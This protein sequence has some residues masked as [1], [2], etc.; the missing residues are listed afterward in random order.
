VTPPDGWL[1]EALAIRDLERF[2]AN[3]AAAGAR[4]NDARHVRS[5]RLLAAEDL[6]LAIAACHDAIG[7]AVTAHMT[8]PVCGHVAEKAPTGSFSI[9]PITNSRTSS[10]LTICGTPTTSVGTRP[11]RIRRL[12]RTPTDPRTHTDLG[13]CGRTDRQRRGQGAG[14]AALAW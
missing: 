4:I 12:C 1:T 14:L 8:Q 13:R 3:M 9:T 10:Q 11:G 2:T 5:A 6:T 7:K